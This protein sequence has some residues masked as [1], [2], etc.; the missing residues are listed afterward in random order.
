MGFASSGEV[1]RY[2]GGIFEAAF[3]DEELAP[4]L[5]GT[6]L[7]LEFRYSDPDATLLV[8]CRTG[9]VSTGGGEGVAAAM[10][11]SADTGNGYWQ[12]KVNLPL[13]MAKGKIKIVGQVAPYRS[14]RVSLV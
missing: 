9:T 2:L 4:K 8:D 13:A 5:E 11:M 10:E 1:Q 14:Q 3:A 7:V 6:G 12:G